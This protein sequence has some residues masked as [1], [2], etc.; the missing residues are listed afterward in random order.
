MTRNILLYV[1]VGLVI[2]SGALYLSSGTFASDTWL[3]RYGLVHKSSGLPGIVVGAQKEFLRL[4]ITILFFAL[5]HAWL[6]ARSSKKYWTGTLHPFSFYRNFLPGARQRTRIVLSLCL[7]SA[8]VYHAY[9]GPTDMHRVWQ[10]NMGDTPFNFREHVLPH[11]FFMFY[12]IVQYFMVAIPLLIVIWESLKLDGSKIRE[13]TEKIGDLGVGTDAAAELKRKANAVESRYLSTRK[14]LL[15]IV[16]RYVFMAILVILYMWIELSALIITLS[17]PGQHI[18]KWAA[19]VFI[20]FV[21]P[22]FIIHGIRAYMRV[23]NQS[24]DTLMRLAASA[25]QPGGSDALPTISEIRGRFQSKYTFLSFVWSLGKSG[26]AALVLFVAVV[27]FVFSQ[28][29]FLDFNSKA[30]PWPVS[31]VVV[32]VYNLTTMDR[33]G[34]GADRHPVAPVCFLELPTEE[35]WERY[36]RSRGR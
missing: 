27:K 24:R 17:C 33:T 21:L 26:S 4:V 36:K 34:D 3:W 29:N 11:L 32:V 8:V 23:F 15:D 35:E 1:L 19:W 5:G 7:V 28:V 31:A 2:G 9:I 6:F 18:L 14:D 16:N 22:Y 25:E 10:E 13:A 30:V 20:V 12:T